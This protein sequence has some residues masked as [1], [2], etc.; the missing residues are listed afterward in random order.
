M[1]AHTG[2]VL[3]PDLD[4]LAA[5]MLRDQVDDEGGEV[6]FMRLQGI[7]VLLRMSRQT[8]EVQPIQPFAH[9]SLRDHHAELSLDL[10]SQIGPA[11]SHDTV[12]LNVRASFHPAR[13]FRLL[14]SSQQTGASRRFPIRQTIRTL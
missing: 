9:R 8:A 5:R 13:Q 12:H 2:F 7:R 4:G 3:E 11:P 1:L 10:G 14:L 6:F